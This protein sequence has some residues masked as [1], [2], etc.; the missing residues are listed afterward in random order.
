MTTN[1]EIN[2]YVMRGSL[3]GRIDRGMGLAILKRLAAKRE[4]VDVA[5]IG[6]ECMFSSAQSKE[7][8]WEHLMTG[9]ESIRG[10]PLHRAHQVEDVLGLPRSEPGDYFTPMG[11]LDEVDGFDASLFRISPK[12]ALTIDP[13]QRLFM[14]AT[15]R[16]LEDAGYAGEDSLGSNTGVFVG[17]DHLSDLDFPYK[18]FTEKTGMLAQTG[19]MPGLLAGRVSHHFNFTGP[20][21]VFDTACSSSLVAL[22]AA[23][24]SLAAGASDVAV[25]GG[26]NVSLYT[27]GHNRFGSV[28]SSHARVH[29]FARNASGTN[30]AE[31]AAAIVLKPL[32]KALED[33]DHVY[34]VVKSVAINNDGATNGVT[35]PSAQAQAQVLTQAW[36]DARIDPSEVSYIEAHGT[37]TLVGDQIELKGLTQAFRQFTERRQFCGLGSL[38]P[39]IG[40]AVGAS[41]IAGL[42]KVTLALEKRALPP[43]IN[44]DEPNGDIHFQESPV[45]LVDSPTPWGNGAEPL[46]AGV[47]SFGFAGTNCHAVLTSA[48]A[49]APG[50]T[51]EGLDVFTLS[52]HERTLA[53]ELVDRFIGYLDDNPGV[54]YADLCFS[55][56]RGR[57]DSKWRMAFVAEDTTDL[58]AQLIRAAEQLQ[59]GQPAWESGEVRDGSAVESLH[60]AMQ[61]F[62][63][64]GRTD[65]VALEETA[66][67]YRLGAD[68]DWAAHYAGQHRRR[69]SLPVSPLLNTK[70]W[71]NA[72]LERP[73]GRGARSVHLSLPV[74][75]LAAKATGDD[76]SG[77]WLVLHEGRPLDLAVVEQL[78]ERGVRVTEV[79]TEAAQSLRPAPIVVDPA[80]PAAL[81][82]GIQ[83]I[84][85]E[86]APDRVLHL[87][88]LAED[89]SL[90]RSYLSILRLIRATRRSAEPVKLTV[91]TADA[92]VARGDG[93]S[94]PTLGALAAG[95]VLV[96]SRELPKLECRQ[97]DFGRDEIDAADGLVVDAL[98]REAASD[99][100]LRQVA[101]SGP[102]RLVPN[103]RE[104][105]PETPRSQIR[106]HGLYL[107]TGGLGGI[108]AALATRLVERDGANVILTGRRAL[109]PASTWKQVSSD[110]D[111]D[112]QLVAQL[113]LLMRLRSRGAVVEYHQVAV[114]DDAAM[115]ALVD[116]CER[117]LGPFAG[118]FHLAGISTGGMIELTDDAQ[119]RRVLSAKVGGTETIG[120]I[121]AARP[122][123]FLMLFSSF[124]ALVGPVALVDYS[125]ACAFQDS[126]A[127][128]TSTPN[129]RVISVSWD[130]WKDV[131][132]LTRIERKSEVDQRLQAALGE[133]ISIDDGME[134]IS[135]ILA[136]TGSRFVV[137][138]RP[139]R[140]MFYDLDKAFDLS[141][142]GD[143]QDPESVFE[144]PD[145]ASPYVAPST[146][147]EFE[148]ADVWQ[149][150]FS[151]REVGLD[152]N[153][154]ELGGDSLMALTITSALNENYGMEVTDL[155]TY[156]TVR[157]LADFLNSRQRNL[158]AEFHAAKVWL[159]S[160]PEAAEQPNTSYVNGRLDEYR[161]LIDEIEVADHPTQSYDSILLLG[162]TGFVG[163]YL[164]HELME[165]TDSRIELLLR[166][167]MTAA[168]DRLAAGHKRYFP[169]VDLENHRDRLAVHEGD[170]MQPMLGL[171]E[172]AYRELADRV[173]AICNSAG[174]VDHYG[175]IEK[176]RDSNVA[177]V[178]R[179]IDLA[180]VGR[181]KHIHHMSTIATRGNV[182]QRDEIYSEFDR[183]IGQEPLNVYAE[184][185]A[186]AEALLTAA[187][188]AGVHVNSYRLGYVCGDSQTGKF[189]P[190]IDK[191]GL[192]LISRALYE[193]T[194]LPTTG[195][196]F[197]EFTMVDDIAKQLVAI[198]RHR[199]L[200]DHT[201][202]LQN[203]HSVGVTEL[204]AAYRLIGRT[205]DEVDSDTFMDYLYEN[206]DGTAASLYVRDFLLHSHLLDAPGLV[207]M[208]VQS[209]WTSEVLD[210]LGLGHTPVKP[211]D[212]A[213]LFRYCQEEGFFSPA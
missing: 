13:K 46:L 193:M 100:G 166:P 25:A 208:M 170:V 176:F 118:V 142:L 180:Q 181:E 97:V 69:L 59:S 202:H 122:L 55:A 45:Y 160:R 99:D 72:V 47:S 10:L 129:Q 71:A 70:Y 26:V 172:D 120:R 179:L 150:V 12:E 151:I 8:F 183:D 161:R 94:V 17:V 109:P 200:L 85:A 7:E 80:D 138:A 34:A 203:G 30:W 175:D 28:E 3:E 49:V 131:G 66:R 199:E 178:R 40:H 119:S 102:A 23:C 33:G 184:T 60:A 76:W 144:R 83:E 84:P 155:F 32:D 107:L 57:R 51:A 130:S 19:S 147:I 61:K 186:E 205:H 103:Y 92:L 187:Q 81:A 88:G 191:N 15:F 195:I 110:P 133:G 18:T 91:V 1:Q 128:A 121:F 108:G 93:A 145:L 198:M 212:L 209:K 167:S 50:A 165:Q 197:W 140:D 104:V 58:K 22:H 74:W 169:D 123:D 37:G 164:L 77:S 152:D 5:I 213:V 159:R 154:Y 6:I 106:P 146:P 11:Y 116:D 14:E 35:S 196:G 113:Q 143:G 38:K 185:K 42:I 21:I 192:Y 96:A 105:E 90:D 207:R 211:E 125:S 95:P 9:R 24:E 73:T 157:E 53:P 86:H 98:L 36:R 89:P 210:R 16:A 67:C 82:C 168:W 78:H 137:T 204:K 101:Y 20:S 64:S 126:Y 135:S 162:A 39:N 132:M 127:V 156:P 190:A 171:N 188:A 27:A 117:R 139:V 174:R 63:A 177:P 163:N 115:T 206:Y 43:S 111:S 62:T 48:P 87:W 124:T 194:V 2:Q 114:D 182:P 134:I 189:Q 141:D 31:G 41:G 68:I 112:R 4:H 79:V 56:N 153:F 75:E 158:Q 149:R 201:F 65:R 54:S 148:V 136:G 52:T 173:D 29:T 44:F